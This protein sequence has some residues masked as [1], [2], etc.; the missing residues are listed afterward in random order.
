MSK[1]YLIA[2]PEIEKVFNDVLEKTTIPHWVEFKVLINDKSKE[3]CDIKKLSD[4]TETL[5]DGLN[6]GVVINE[7]IYNELPEDIVKLAIEEALSGVSISETDTI[8]YQKGDFVTHSGFLSKYGNE[9]VQKMKGSIKSV[10]DKLKEEEDK[11]KAQ[12][13]GK[14]GRKPKNSL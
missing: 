12:S 2:D 10:K 4:L 11:L 14:R 5:T 1:K 13:K 9:S 6:F 7:K 8:S 3:L